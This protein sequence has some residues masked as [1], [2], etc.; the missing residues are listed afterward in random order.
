MIA[1]EE[2]WHLRGSQLMELGVKPG[3]IGAHPVIAAE[4][5]LVT[6]DGCRVY[7]RSPNETSRWLALFLNTGH[8][9]N[10]AFQVHDLRDLTSPPGTSSC[11]LLRIP[12]I[13]NV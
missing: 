4:E 5:V 10:N 1:P 11:D 7:S 8:R 9:G 13:L 12:V 3:A 2:L 6:V